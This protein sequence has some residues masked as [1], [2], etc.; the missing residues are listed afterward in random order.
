LSHATTIAFEMNTPPADIKSQRGHSEKPELRF[1]E[2]LRAARRQADLT[3]E[4]VAKRAG[5]SKAFVSQ[6]ERNASQISVANLLRLCDVLGIDVGALLRAPTAV[7]IR[8]SDKLRIEFGGHGVQD[9]LLTPSDTSALRVLEANIEPGGYSGE[10]PYSLKVAHETAFVLQG[11]I[12]ITVDE[13]THT[14]AAGDALT[15]S[16]GAVHSWRNDS[17]SRP[18]RVLWM[19]VLSP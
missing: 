12:S 16:G 2:K 8:G 19:L 9:F 3:I 18:A 6:I 5:L 13:V 11:S 15:I 4:E 7:L 10:E 14:L 17:T 1:G